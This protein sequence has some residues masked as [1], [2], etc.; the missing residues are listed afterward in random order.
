MNIYSAGHILLKKKIW[1]WQ[2]NSSDL[3]HKAVHRSNKF[4]VHVLQNM[5]GFFFFKWMDNLREAGI[6]EQTNVYILVYRYWNTSAYLGTI[7]I[8]HVPIYYSIVGR[9]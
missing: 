7:P 4:K 1:Q 6:E 2:K 9:S 8:L 3:E 5:F